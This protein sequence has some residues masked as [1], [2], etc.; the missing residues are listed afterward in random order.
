MAMKKFINNPK[1]LTPELLEGFVIAH[2]DLVKLVSEKIVCRAQPK[3]QNKVALVT[4]GGAGHEPAL[5]GFVGPGMLDF[6][7]V[8]DIFAAP[9]PPKVI[10]ALRLARRDAGILFVVLNHAGDVMSANMAMEMADKE[11]IRYKMILTHEDIAPGADAPAE[12]RRGLVGALPLYKIAGAAAEAGKSL[13][14]VYTLAERF[15]QNMATLAVAMKTATHPAT[16]QSIFEL[17]DDE[18]EIGMGQHGEAGTGP[19]KI[20]T[21]DQTAEM[22]LTRLLEAIKAR[23]GDRLLLILNGSGATTLMEL[24]IVLRACKKLLDARGLQLAAAEVG[25][26]LTVQEMAGFQMFVAKMDDELLHYYQAPCH[27]PAWTRP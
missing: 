2:G 14:D 12:D 5:S 8:G 17:A 22:M 23:Q 27:T 16:G 20:M 13:E 4:L 26:F 3:P 19:C 21:A 9:G 15:N 1:N 6:S 7:V 18:M 11:G 10:E 25:E 24:Y